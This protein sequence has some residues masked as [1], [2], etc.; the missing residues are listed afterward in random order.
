MTI[1]VEGIADARLVS[2]DVIRDVDV[3]VTRAPAAAAQPVGRCDVR[4]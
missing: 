4:R 3:F 2:R 1:D